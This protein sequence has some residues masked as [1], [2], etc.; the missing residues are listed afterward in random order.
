MDSSNSGRRMEEIILGVKIKTGSLGTTGQRT[1][2]L[3]WH[4]LNK[5]KK[6]NK[7][8]IEYQEFELEEGCCV[9]KFKVDVVYCCIVVLPMCFHG[10]VFI[11]KLF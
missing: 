9:T 3:E 2:R 10:Y 1:K 6:I 11:T 8:V 5:R 7:L 4:S